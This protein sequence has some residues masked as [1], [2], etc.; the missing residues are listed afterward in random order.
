MS[1][2]WS[3]KDGHAAASEVTLATST[4]R[5]LVGSAD[6]WAGCRGAALLVT[7]DAGHGRNRGLVPPRGEGP[8]GGPEAWAPT[9]A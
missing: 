1:H 7:A 4:V 5:A 3:C 9:H 2:S 6:T 8:A